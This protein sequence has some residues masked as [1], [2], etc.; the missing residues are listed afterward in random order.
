MCGVAGI[1]AREEGPPPDERMLQRM[2]ASLTHRGPDDEGRFTDSRIAF[3]ARRLSIIDV[4]GGHQPIGNEDGRVQV[5]LNGE[6]YNYLELTAELEQSGHRFRSRFGC[7]CG[8]TQ[9]L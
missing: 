8:R 1:L 9:N 5:V 7:L 2:L 4:D 3:G 6:I